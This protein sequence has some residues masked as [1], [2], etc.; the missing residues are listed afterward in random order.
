MAFRHTNPPFNVAEL[1]RWLQKEFQRLEYELH[2]YGKWK[3]GQWDDLRFPASAINKPGAASDPIWNTSYVGYQFSGSAENDLQIVAQIP[4]SWKLDTNIR[5][6]IHVECAS[7]SVLATHVWEMSYRWRNNGE[8]LTAMTT[9]TITCTPTSTACLQIHSFPE[10]NGLNKRA[11][12]ILDIE[13][14]RRGDTDSFAGEVI[15][16]EFDIHILIDSFGSDAEL[17]K[18]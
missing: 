17:Y 18:R 12:S 16:K 5:P 1:S 14:S 15:L 10:L 13:I 11:S 9:H 8:T 7:G 6:H 4:H 2:D 3:G